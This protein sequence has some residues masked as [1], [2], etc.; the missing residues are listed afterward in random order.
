MA[1]LLAIEWMTPAVLLCSVLLNRMLKQALCRTLYPL[2]PLAVTLHT[3]LRI[4]DIIL[5]V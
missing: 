3:E 2:K 1:K 4:S 5:C